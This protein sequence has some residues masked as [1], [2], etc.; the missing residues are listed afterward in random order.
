MDPAVVALVGA[1]SGAGGTYLAQTKLVE[2][3]A[4]RAWRLEQDR[5][6]DLIRRLAAATRTVRRRPY[7]R[8]TDLLRVHPYIGIE[9][10]VTLGAEPYG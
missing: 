10:P 7:H 3:A 9:C 8:L 4:A 1:L 6:T 2:T 5:E